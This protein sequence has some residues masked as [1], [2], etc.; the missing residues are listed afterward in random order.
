HPGGAAGALFPRAAKVPVAARVLRKSRRKISTGSP[1]SS[2]TQQHAAPRIRRAQPAVTPEHNDS[3]SGT[4]A[5]KGHNRRVSSER[6][7]PSYAAP[8]LSCGPKPVEPP[9]RFY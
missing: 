8:K 7:E 4:V 1:M 5:G 9:T 3:V 6:R 2:A